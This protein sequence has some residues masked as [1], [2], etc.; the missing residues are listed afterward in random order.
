MTTVSQSMHVFGTVFPGARVSIGAKP[1]ALEPAN[2]G[3]SLPI[4]STFATEVPV[5]LDHLVAAV[6]VDDAK[7]T[8]FYVMHPSAVVL[9]ACGT[10]IAE[11]K[12][13]A[14][15]LDDQGDHAGALKTLETAIAACKPDRDTLSLALTYACKAGDAKAATTYWRKLPAELQRTIEPV[16]A[17]NAIM[18]DALDKR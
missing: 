2:P 7:G 10:T 18:R 17:S 5:S 12:Q 8:H 3:D 6:R 13:T 11:P 1:V 16:C 15:K 9:N 4:G 14:A